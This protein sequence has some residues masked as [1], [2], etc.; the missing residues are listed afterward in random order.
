M[1]RVR[2]RLLV[3][4]M[5]REERSSCVGFHGRK[6]TFRL[7]GR[8]KEP[9]DPEKWIDVLTRDRK[10]FDIIAT[11]AARALRIIIIIIIM[12]LLIKTCNRLSIVLYRCTCVDAGERYNYPAERLSC[13]QQST[14][15]CT[16]GRPYPGLYKLDRQRRS[17]IVASHENN[18]RLAHID[19]F[20]LG[21]LPI[22][23]WLLRPVDLWTS[24]TS[25]GPGG[26]RPHRRSSSEGPPPS[27]H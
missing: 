8:L 24:I 22:Y 15:T 23:E 21:P 18:T 2:R 27:I 17:A 20:K 16:G 1:V 9:S 10:K 19:L 25:A 12:L 11:C 13:Q 3:L 26:R 4:M 14:R 6:W 5:R 7:V